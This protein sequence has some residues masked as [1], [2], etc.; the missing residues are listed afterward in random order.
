MSTGSVKW[1]DEMYRIFARH[2]SQG[3]PTFPDGYISL[4]HPDNWPRITQMVQNGADFGNDIEMN[5]RLIWPDGTTHYIVVKA[6]SEK[7]K[8]GQIHQVV[9]I[10]QDITAW[11]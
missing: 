9:G 6:H 3:E 7:T 1:S 11:R 8:S 4:I 10:I 2:R 5:L